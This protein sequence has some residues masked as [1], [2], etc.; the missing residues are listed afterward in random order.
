MNIHNK[1]AMLPPM[2]IVVNNVI[3]IIILQDMIGTLFCEYFGNTKKMKN[4]TILRMAI[5]PHNQ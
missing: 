2:Y 1:N 3:I 4:I 5:Q